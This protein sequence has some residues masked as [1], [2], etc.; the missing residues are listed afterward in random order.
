MFDPAET[1]AFYKIFSRGPLTEDF[2]KK[3][4]EDV[5]IIKTIPWRAY[6]H[7]TPPEKFSPF[8]LEKG[9]VYINTIES[10]ASAM[11]MSAV[12]GKNAALLIHHFLKPD[13]PA[14]VSDEKQMNVEL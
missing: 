13:A 4:F 6:P 12:G 10:A 3:A 8:I 5:E 1:N 11:E 14:T 2:Q 9:L 7:F